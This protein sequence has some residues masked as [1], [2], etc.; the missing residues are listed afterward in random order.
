MKPRATLYDLLRLAPTASERD[1]HAAHLRL[2]RHYQSGPHG[3]QPADADNR[4][5]AIKEAWWVLSDPVRRA[6]YDASLTPDAPPQPEQAPWPGMPLPVE[7]ELKSLKRSPLRIMLTIIGVLMI[8]GMT[9]Q[10]FFSVF[11]FRQVS[12]IAGGDAASAAQAQTA[13]AERRANYGNLTDKEIAEQEDAAIRR[14][15]EYRQQEAERRLDYQRKE[16]E[17]QRERALQER[18]QYADQV[19]ADLQRAEEAARQKAE[20]ERQQKEARERQIQAEED[21]RLQMRLAQERARLRLG[22]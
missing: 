9:I 19:S 7:I 8:V 15:E 2:V 20:W 10:I 3:L 18:K 1:I 16:E 11:A 21:A 22:N 13:A 6:A 12:R 4:I 14:R 5:K 17:R